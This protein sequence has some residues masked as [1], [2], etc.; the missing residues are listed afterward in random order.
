MAIAIQITTISSRW[1][2]LLER[3]EGGAK[4]GKTTTKNARLLPLAQT[5]N[6]VPSP[7][8]IQKVS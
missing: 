4:L 8:Q 3:L 1:M 6:G 7:R 2:R 5:E